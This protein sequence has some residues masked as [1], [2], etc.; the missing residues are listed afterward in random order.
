M[1]SLRWNIFTNNFDYVGSGG[2]GGGDVNGPGSS[3]IGGIAV[4]NDTSGTLLGELPT[5]PIPG[6]TV[7]SNGSVASYAAPQNVLNYLD[8]CISGNGVGES[9]PQSIGNW[10]VDVSNSGQVTGSFNGSGANHPGV[11]QVRVL[12]ADSS[13]AMGSSSLV[14]GGGY[15][16]ISMIIMTPILSTGTNRFTTTYGLS[17]DFALSGT[18]NGLIFTY[19]D[20]ANSGNWIC[21][22][23]SSG[24][25]TSVNT[26]VAVDTAW[27]KLTVKV[28]AAATVA[29]F[30]IDDVLVATINTNVPSGAFINAY[31]AIASDPIDYGSVTRFSRIDL[32]TIYKEINTSRY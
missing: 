4:W 16:E 14:L 23:V 29:T 7:I 13:A 2:G 25:S 31:M 3:T 12:A 17:D 10:Y 1:T 8:D 5:D 22:A 19:S 26:S 11:Y 15:F 18:T 6:S 24:V 28:D 30:F 9:T 32:L 21:T 27:H 20:N